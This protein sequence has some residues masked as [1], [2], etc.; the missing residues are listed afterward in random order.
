MGRHGT[1]GR[2]GGTGAAIPPEAG[3]CKRWR[4]LLHL[5]NPLP[6]AAHCPRAH[7]HTRPIL[8]CHN[9]AEGHRKPALLSQRLLRENRV[10]WPGSAPA[11]TPSSLRWSLAVQRRDDALGVNVG[12]R[13]ATEAKKPKDL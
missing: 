5:Q 13:G 12:Q 9:N 11:D 8:A 1:V 4:V 10:A 3:F 2:R 7:T 6:H